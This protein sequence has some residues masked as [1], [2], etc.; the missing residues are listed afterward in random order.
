MRNRRN[1][2]V[3]PLWLEVWVT[4]GAITV[5]AFWGTV[6]FYMLSKFWV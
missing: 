6:S 1:G 5:A 2:R 4:I 3:V